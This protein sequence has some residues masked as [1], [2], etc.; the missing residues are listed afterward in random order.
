[1]RGFAIGMMVAL[2]ACGG[3]SDT[4]EKDDPTDTTDAGFTL[5]VDEAHQ[6]CDQDEDCQTLYADCSSC[7]C[8]GVAAD[9]ADL[10]ADAL[11]CTGYMGAE[12]DYDCM[13]VFGLEEPRCVDHVCASVPVGE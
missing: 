6:A 12:C 1:M 11:D 2:V 10:Y 13:P 3:D 4:E 7:V 8:V 5:T 9:Y